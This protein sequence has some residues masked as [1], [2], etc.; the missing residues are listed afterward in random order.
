MNKN[1]AVGKRLTYTVLAGSGTSVMLCTGMDDMLA[2]R[3]QGD[4]PRCA[5]PRLRATIR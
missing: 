3:Q 5:G 1:A 4:S 2:K